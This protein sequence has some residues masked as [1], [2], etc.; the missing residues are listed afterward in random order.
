MIH[1]HT[2]KNRK[3]CS[4]SIT[5]V[6]L[7]H[8]GHSLLCLSASNPPSAHSRPQA[9]PARA[10]RGSRAVHVDVHA[11]VLQGLRAREDFHEAAHKAKVMDEVDTLLRGASDRARFVGFKGE[12]ETHQLGLALEALR[13]LARH[14]P[15]EPVLHAALPQRLPQPHPE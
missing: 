15:D 5:N 7:T 2:S 14:L 1:P 13:D 11:N 8:P 3:S 10:A 9:R 4:P 12:M 6:P